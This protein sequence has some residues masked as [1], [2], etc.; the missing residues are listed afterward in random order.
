MSVFVNFKICDNAVE[1]SGI[2]VCPSKALYW[3]GNEKTVVTDNDK[4]MSCDLCVAA[5]PAGA[6]RVAHNLM[7]EIQIEKDIEDDPRTL[8]DLMVERYGASPV[9]ETTL[10]SVREAEEHIAKNSLL[11]IIEIIDNDDTPCLINSV[12]ISEIF[13]DLGYDYFKITIGDEM[14]NSFAEKY[15]INDCPTL[16]VFKSSELIVRMDGGVENGD[17]FQRTEFIQKITNEIRY[18]K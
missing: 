3:D 14:Y 10:I 15:L 12:P 8:K 16:L 7:E 6:I 18:L 17:Y 4:C 1:C 13:G 11:T 2:E 5:C 9:N